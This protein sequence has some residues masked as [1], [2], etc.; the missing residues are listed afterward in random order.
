MSLSKFKELKG[1]LLRIEESKELAV[2][3]VQQLRMP[4]AGDAHR[5]L[6]NTLRGADM[7]IFQ[8]DYFSSF[9]FIRPIRYRIS[10]N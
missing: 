7:L 3:Q 9:A 8:L 2:R 10:S 6:Q 5:A 4:C 1:C